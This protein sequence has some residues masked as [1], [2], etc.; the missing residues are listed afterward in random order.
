LEIKEKEYQ[1]A[2]NKSYAN[3]LNNIALTFQSLKKFDI[4]VRKYSET[5]I[6]YKLPGV[7]TT[8]DSGEGALAFATTCHSL[9]ECYK[10]LGELD[11]AL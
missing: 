1:R 8:L 2:P 3:T 5:L 10:G 6:Y 7:Y 4:A 11:G 9:A